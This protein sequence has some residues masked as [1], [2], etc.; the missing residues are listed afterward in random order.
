MTNRE[1]LLTL[2]LGIF[3]T[4]VGFYFGSEVAAKGQAPEETIVRTVPLRLTAGPATASLTIVSS[5]AEFTI[6]T[7]VSGG[8]APYRYGVGL[9]KDDIKTETPVDPSGWIVKAISAP[10]A[11]ADRPLQVRV[12]I[13]DAD[14]HS[15]ENSVLV[16]I[17]AGP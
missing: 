13:E 10:K 17:K 9:D 16:L 4:I 15:A 1:K 11:T 12:V 6:N 2:L 7:F 3:G 5:G 8:K 14:G